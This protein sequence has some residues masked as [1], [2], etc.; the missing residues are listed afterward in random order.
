MFGIER[1]P[2]G[3]ASC[4]ACK[5][6]IDAGDWRYHEEEPSAEFD[7]SYRRYYHLRC[8]VE[9]R[10][11]GASRALSGASDAME[12]LEWGQLLCQTLLYR[13]RRRDLVVARP[14][15]L[16][17]DEDGWAHLLC[18]LDSGEHAVVTELE[19]EW[20]ACVERTRD[21]ALAVLPGPVFEI[22]VMALA[23]EPKD[24]RE[25]ARTLRSLQR[26]RAAKRAADR[27]A[28]GQARRAA[29]VKAKA[30]ARAAGVELP[31]ASIKSGS[32][33]RIT[34]DVKST[35]GRAGKGVCGEVFWCGYS[36]RGM[37]KRVGLRGDNGEKYWANL[38][39]VEPVSGAGGRKRGRRR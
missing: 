19:G 7:G 20:V 1:S 11:A 35:R 33:V 12:R 14:L 2:S 3:R 23:G 26:S 13:C 5:A 24:Q 10:A 37:Q 27:K 8:A 28:L 38:T 22:A 25:T 4:R 39:E 9:R 6:R 21:D 17:L 16:T 36:K 34:A 32:R 29:T 15:W 31:S 30:E 18:E